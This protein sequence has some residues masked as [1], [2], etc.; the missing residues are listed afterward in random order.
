MKIKTSLIFS[1]IVAM[2]F[3]TACSAKSGNPDQPSS[4]IGSSS[5][6]SSETPSGTGTVSPSET[7]SSGT[8][9]GTETKV[10]SKT[11]LSLYDGKNG[12]P[13]YVA[14]NGIVYDVTNVRGWHNGTHQGCYAGQDVTATFPHGSFV[15]NKVPV[16]GTYEG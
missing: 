4:G 16:V 11:E 9:P 10:F 2:T 8:S 3:L 7:P 1:L 13:A 15:F 5:S 6:S 12:N 14:V